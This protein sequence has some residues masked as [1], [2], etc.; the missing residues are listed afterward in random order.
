MKTH[1]C[2]Q[3]ALIFALTDHIMGS[4]NSSPQLPFWLPTLS[5]FPFLNLSGHRRGPKTAAG[6]CRFCAHPVPFKG[7]YHFSPSINAYLLVMIIHF[8]SMTIEVGNGSLSQ[9]WT[10]TL[11]VKNNCEGRG[12]SSHELKTLSI[13]HYV[14]LCRVY[15]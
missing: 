12:S 6:G 8:K 2:H 15:L 11:T 5:F 13:R 14:W 3:R 10:S 7:S 4:E 1:G 9:R